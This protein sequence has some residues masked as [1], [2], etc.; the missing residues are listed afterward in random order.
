[1]N[2]MSVATRMAHTSVPHSYEGFSIFILFLKLKI[3]TVL[4]R[5]YGYF[6]VVFNV[7]T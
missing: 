5:P 1:M 7:T 2:H 4:V 6:Y 3:H